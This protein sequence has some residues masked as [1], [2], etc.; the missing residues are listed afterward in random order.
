MLDEIG[1]S[2][3]PMV[4]ALNKVDLVDPET[5]LREEFR[6][7]GRA[8]A[9]G[10]APRAVPAGMS[11]HISR[12]GE[13]GVGIEDLLEVVEQALRDELAPCRAVIPTRPGELVHTWHRYGIVDNEDLR[14]RRVHI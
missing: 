5:L 1:A 6:R 2:G 13:Q 10:S 9:D 7:V 11:C 8:V 4:L 14:G 3:K 12:L